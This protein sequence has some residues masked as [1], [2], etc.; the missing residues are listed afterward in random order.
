MINFAPN[1]NKYVSHEGH[2]LG[3]AFLKDK[4]HQFV[5]LSTVC[6]NQ[7]KIYQFIQ[8]LDK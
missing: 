6:P 4:I 3:K 7:D 2:A 5:G 8:N 1:A